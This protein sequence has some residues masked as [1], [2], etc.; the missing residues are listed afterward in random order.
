MPG[1]VI[2][3]KPVVVVVAT[4]KRSVHE[5]VDSRFANEKGGVDEAGHEQEEGDEID[6]GSDDFLIIPETG[7]VNQH[8]DGSR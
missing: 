4:V 6:A 2:S 3:P 7:A 8:A 1:R 5:T